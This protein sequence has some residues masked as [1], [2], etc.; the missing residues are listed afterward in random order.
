[1]ADALA[2]WDVSGRTSSNNSST[3]IA[4]GTTGADLTVGS[5]T[6]GGGVSSSTTAK[7]FGGSGWN[8]ASEA[9]AVS[10]GK[11]ETF[12][13]TASAGYQVSF[14]TLHLNYRAS[15]TGPASGELQY[16]SGAGAFVDVASLAYS[17]AGAAT[18]ESPVDLSGIAALQNVAAGTTVTFRIVNW[19]ASSSGGTWYIGDGTGNDL[20][21]DGAVAS[22]NSPVNGNCGTANG[23]FFSAAPTTNLCAAGT[24]SAVGGSGPWNWSC[25][26]SGGGTAAM[27][28]ASVQSAQPLT[29]FH[30]NDVH[31]RITPHPWVIN[32]HGPDTGFE[33]V[34]GAAYLAGEYLSL[35]NGDPT[36]LVL[37][38]G[39]ISEGNPLGDMNCS[40]QTLAQ[41]GNIA[42][43]A[44]S[45]NC[46][47][48]TDGTFQYGNGGLTAAYTL[49]HEKLADRKSVV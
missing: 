9:A 12:T 1:M 37:D 24:A 5:L 3:P 32:Q 7:T 38:G 26:G 46:A 29:I 2:G 19:G 34:G 36:A 11:Y 20:E 21:I 47:T 10:A 31:A 18:T 45:I 44:A 42:A 48:N 16:Q 35:V 23:K 4:A 28:S 13:V 6:L 15:S 49:L 40:M 41:A 43:Q 22:A 33:P 17:T 39:D 14:T 25:A 27:C 8:V 30:S